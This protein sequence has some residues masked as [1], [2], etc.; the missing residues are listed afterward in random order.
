MTRLARF[1]AVPALLV[2]TAGLATASDIRDKANLFSAEAVTKAESDLNRIEKA[3][4]IPI[5]IETIES[6]EGQP[7]KDVTTR[8]AE[9]A[10][11]KGLYV[12][13]SKADSK[14]Y[15]EAS[16]AFR[17]ALT[18]DRIQGI[19]DAFVNQF[20]KKDFDAG[21]SRGVAKI[22]TTVAEAR[23]A[24]APPGNRRAGQP[25]IAGKPSSGGMSMWLVI[26]LG[27]LALFIVLRVLGSLFGGNRGGYAGQARGMGPGAMGGPGYGGGGYGGGGGGGGFMSSMFGG[28]GGALAGNWLYDQFSGRHHDSS[29]NQSNYDAGSAPAET[30]PE[31]GSRRCRR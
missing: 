13:I 28:I 7:V 12:L 5:T 27:I 20:K 2:A 10:N 23:P 8:H 25:P 17:T 18:R 9:Q 24:T 14:M 3:Y 31:W 6:L 11:A 22:E 29:M 15:V 1:L 26:G 30:G 4:A 21:L 16:R 19:D